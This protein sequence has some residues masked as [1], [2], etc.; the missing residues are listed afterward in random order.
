MPCCSARSWPRFDGAVVTL[1]SASARPGPAILGRMLAAAPW[2]I[3]T[4]ADEAGDKAASA[5]PA[6]ARRVRPPEGSRTGPSSITTGFNRIRYLWG[7][8]VKTVAPT[9]WEE[10]AA[11]RWGPAARRPRGRDRHRPA[12]PRPDAGGPASRRR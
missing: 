5:W 8:I 2:F 11:W 7:G 10:L 9:S 4:D 3:A 6:R 12:R 1:G